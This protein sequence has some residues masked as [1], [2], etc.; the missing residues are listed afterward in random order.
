MEG[1]EGNRKDGSK[2][3][4]EAQFEAMLLE[5]IAHKPTSCPGCAYDL[6]GLTR[7]RC[8]ECGRKLE[9]TV[10]TPD[11]VMGLWIGSVVPLALAAGIGLLFLFAVV[12]G[13]MPPARMGGLWV[14]FLSSWTAILAVA[15]LLRWR[16]AYLRSPRGRQEVLCIFAWLLAAAAFGGLVVESLSR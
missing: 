5:L 13:G 9:L 10:G 2:R 16:H 3:S 7:P 12:Q 8:P 6:R 14:S 4:S 1:N 15:A 11:P